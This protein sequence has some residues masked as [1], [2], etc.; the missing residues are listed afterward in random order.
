V[1]IVYPGGRPTML[2]L[3]GD[4]IP[5]VRVEVRERPIPPRPTDGDYQTDPAYRAGFQQWLNG[6]WVEKDAEIERLLA[7]DDAAAA[8]G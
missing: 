2:D 4:R 3:M 6:L 1:T 5:E 8:R 7:Q